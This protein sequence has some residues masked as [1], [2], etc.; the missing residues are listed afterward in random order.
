MHSY[1]VHNFIFF[2][3]K[4]KLFSDVKVNLKNVLRYYF[5]FIAHTGVEQTIQLLLLH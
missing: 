5:C 1:C 2:Q 3:N 4:T